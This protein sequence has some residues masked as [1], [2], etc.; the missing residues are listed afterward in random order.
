[1]DNTNFSSE[2]LRFVKIS[3]VKQARIWYKY[4]PITQM[5]AKGASFKW[6]PR[7]SF[8]RKSSGFLLLKSPFLCFRVIQTGY[9]IGQILTWK[10]FSLLK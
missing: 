8:P 5:S 7:A 1:M 4:W 6:G 9:D 2:N 10:V 3:I